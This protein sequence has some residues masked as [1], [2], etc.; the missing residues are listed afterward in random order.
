MNK[1]LKEPLP[2]LPQIDATLE[3]NPSPEY[4]AA[5]VDEALRY[6]TLDQIAAHTGVARRSVVNYKADGFPRY[7]VQLT[8]EIFA[9]VRRLNHG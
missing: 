6:W 8:M 1:R 2:E 5:V 4:A 3:Y 9:G 7:P